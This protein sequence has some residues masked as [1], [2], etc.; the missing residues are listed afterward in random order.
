MAK[1]KLTQEE[2]VE[3][4]IQASKFH[5]WCVVDTDNAFAFNG[6]DFKIDSSVKQYIVKNKGSENESEMDKILCIDDEDSIRFFD[7]S[8][9]E[10]KEDLV[11]L[12]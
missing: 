8:L 3:Q 5:G 12:L 4:L 1:K 6:F 7:E 9:K 11:E 2:K 10:L